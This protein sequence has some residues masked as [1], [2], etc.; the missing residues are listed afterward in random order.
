MRNTRLPYNLFYRLAAYGFLLSLLFQGCKGCGNSSGQESAPEITY[1]PY[2]IHL[3]IL[4]QG[5]TE[6]QGDQRS[7]QFTIEMDPYYMNLNR[8]KF[9]HA[10][11]DRSKLK[12]E[13]CKDEANVQ[14]FYQGKEV[15]DG[16]SLADLPV[17][18][19]PIVLQVEPGEAHYVRL[20]LQPYHRTVPLSA[21]D[22]QQFIWFDHGGVALLRTIQ[23][24]YDIKRMGKTGLLYRKQDLPILLAAN[25]EAIKGLS[26]SET[27]KYLYKVGNRALHTAVERYEIDLVEELLKH[28]VKVDALNKYTQTPLMEAV[29]YGNEEL[30]QLLLKYKANTSATDSE[31]GTPLTY[32]TYL[33]IAAPGLIQL[34]I[35][36]GANVDQVDREGRAPLFWAVNAGNQDKVALF[37]K[38][39][40]ESIRLPIQTRHLYYWLLKRVRGTK[41]LFSYY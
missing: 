4:P 6:L 39:Q 29:L 26:N 5:P 20:T 37:I 40:A 7:I 3:K 24:L 38:H 31:G 9:E 41:K 10:K 30:T 2:A 28:G 14:L 36:H 21:G 33:E 23:E 32:A 16:I 19:Q 15:G 17:F 11:I 13:I 18:G 1:D 25:K 27:R 35:D 12:L 22:I 8:Y 34:L